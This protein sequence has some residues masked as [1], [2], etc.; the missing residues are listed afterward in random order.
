M[1]EE[2]GHNPIATIAGEQLHPVDAKVLSAQVDD[3]AATFAANSDVYGTG[4][5]EAAVAAERT[6][7]AAGL[8]TVLELGAGQGR[9]TLHLARN[10]LHVTALDCTAA[11]AADI[12][13]K[14]RAAGLDH[15]IDV[16]LMTPVMVPATHL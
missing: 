1:A 2:K 14:A 8:S 10:S 7:A 4:S 9:D 5:C 3:W 12:F 16:R 13:T 15:K 11:A 6:F